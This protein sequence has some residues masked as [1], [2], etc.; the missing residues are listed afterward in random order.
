MEIRQWIKADSILYVS[1]A[2]EGENW[3]ASKVVEVG[4]T[5]FCIVKPKDLDSPFFTPS[6]GSV[7]VRAPSSEGLFQ[8]TC[9]VLSETQ[10]AEPRVE[11]DFPKEVIHLERRA[12][13]RIPVEMETHYAEIR[14]GSAGLSFSKSTALDISGG[15]IRLETNRNCPQEALLRVKFQIPLGQMEEELILT[16]RIVRSVPG[17]GARKSQVGVEF[18]DIT[19]RQQESLMQY[20]LDHTKAQ[21]PQA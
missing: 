14:D 4:S 12:Y 21:R 17:E 18:I 3:Y 11:L 20:I 13:I 6:G 7:R 15:G 8:L 16:G 1:P 10:E 2:L 9:A 19:P 5:S